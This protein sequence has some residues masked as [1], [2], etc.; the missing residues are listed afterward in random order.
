MGLYAVKYI[1]YVPVRNRI[2]DW[3]TLRLTVF[4]LYL[5]S[6]FKTSEYEILRSRHLINLLSAL[7]NLLEQPQEG[8]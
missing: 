7:G 5:M 8:T 4:L 6:G 2:Q 3:M 1:M